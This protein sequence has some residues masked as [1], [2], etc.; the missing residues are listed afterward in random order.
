MANRKAHTTTGWLGLF[1]LGACAGEPPAH[2]ASAPPPAGRAAAPAAAPGASTIDARMQAIADEEVARAVDAWRAEAGVVLVLEASTGAILASAGRENGAPADVAARR[3]FIT[4][5]TLK[6]FTLA[7]A[8]DEGA[9]SPGESFDCE[10][11][12]FVYRG[13]RMSDP[14]PRGV[15]TVPEMLATSTNVGFTKVYDRLGGE[16]LGRR[17]RAFRFGVAPPVEGATA[18]DAPKLEAGTSYEGAVL[19]IGEAMAASP[20][21]LAAAY[22]ALANDGAYVAP[23]LAPAAAAAPAR[24]QVVK[25]ETARAVMRM[26]DGVVNGEL[27]TGKLARFDGA[28]V[29][30]KTGTAAWSLPNGG[31]GAYASFVGVVPA[32]PPRSSRL[33]ILVGLLQPHA[34]NATGGA[35]AAP[36]FAR[37]ASRVLAP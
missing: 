15:L 30:G 28:R 21:Q 37:V 31:E 36:A 17:L 8:L 34:E 20:L 9:V 27:G 32:P 5:S 1:L 29:A 18:G 12:S 10:G 24:E 13:K 26:L 11:G 23:T 2:R 33:V 25:P 3:A 19:A 7:A 16:R 4:G 14:T 35:A 6:S 22:G